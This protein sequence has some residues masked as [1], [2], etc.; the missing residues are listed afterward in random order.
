V[1]G[2]Y[3]DVLDGGRGGVKVPFSSSRLLMDLY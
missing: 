1:C 2:V 3:E